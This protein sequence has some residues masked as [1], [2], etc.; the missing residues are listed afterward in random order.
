MRTITLPNGK[1]VLKPFNRLWIVLPVFMAI[2]IGFSFVIPINWE[3]ISFEQLVVI[4]KKMFTPG[5]TRTWGDYFAFMLTLDDE[6]IDTLKMSLAGT[7]I[8]C[9]LAIPVAI[10]SASNVNKVKWLSIP[11]KFFLNLM[12]TI[13]TLMWTAIVIILVGLGIL[14]GIIAIALFSFGI[15]GKMLYEAIETVDMAPFEALESTGANKAQ[16]FR[17]S[18]FTQIAPIYISYTIYIFEINIR[19]SAM[20]GYVGAGGL[21]TVIKDNVM[22][23]YDRVGATIIV[24]FFL[25]LIIQILSNFVRS[26]LQ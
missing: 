6:I 7:L 2:C 8:G 21:G 10:I 22:Y 3:S 11:V 25:I 16:A 23:R 9:I 1:S 20:L 4:I 26:K 13:P 14:P 15:M 17:Y 24:M 18:I 19:S 12:R 5:G